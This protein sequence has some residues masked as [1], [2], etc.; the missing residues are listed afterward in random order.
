MVDGAPNSSNAKNSLN[1]LNLPTEFISN[2]CVASRGA[3]YNLPFAA[4]VMPPYL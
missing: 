3:Q 2:T 4:D 1:E